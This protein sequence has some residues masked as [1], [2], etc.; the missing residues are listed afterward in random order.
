MR[1]LVGEGNLKRP[2]QP[3]VFPSQKRP[4][5]AENL[6]KRSIQ[7]GRLNLEPSQATA[8][9]HRPP[10]SER[11]RVRVWVRAL[12]GWST[13]GGTAKKKQ[14]FAIKLQIGLF[15]RSHSG[16]YRGY[17]LSIYDGHSNK[18]TSGVLIHHLE[19][20]S[21]FRHTT[22]QY[23]AQKAPSKKRGSTEKLVFFCLFSEG[24]KRADRATDSGYSCRIS[25]RLVTKPRRLPTPRYDMNRKTACRTNTREKSSQDK[26]WLVV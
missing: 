19:I 8:S 1:T 6:S 16:R 2:I 4:D 18:H 23:E 5:P 15:F 13:L 26:I 24:E 17:S 9:K 20:L 7:S 11:V 14:R 25:M 12:V 10:Y 3:R 21:P 22:E